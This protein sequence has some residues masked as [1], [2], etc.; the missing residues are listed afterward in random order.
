MKKEELIDIINIVEYFRIKY[1]DI[2]DALRLKNVKWLNKD[3]RPMTM[4]EIS[5]QVIKDL[6]SLTNIIYDNS[7][8]Y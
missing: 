3:G 4:L 7:K 8:K 5:E 1:S 2:S 6:E